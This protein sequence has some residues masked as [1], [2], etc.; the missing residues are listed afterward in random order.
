[1]QHPDRFTSIINGSGR[2]QYIDVD[3]GPIGFGGFSTKGESGRCGYDYL[4]SKESL[5]GG[6]GW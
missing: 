6:I 4:N 5:G 2:Y 3:L 1:M